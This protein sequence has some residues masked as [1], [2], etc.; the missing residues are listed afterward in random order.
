[1]KPLISSFRFWA[2]RVSGRFWKAELRAGIPRI[3][4]FGAAL[5]TIL[6]SSLPQEAQAQLLEQYLPA[7]VTGYGSV[8]GVPVLARQR[9]EFDPAG[10]RYGT[11]V[12]HPEASTGV[13]YNS[14][15]TGTSG[16]AGGVSINTTA[17]VIASS[18]WSLGSLTAFANVENTE[19]PNLSNQSTT[20]WS[21]GGAGAYQVDRDTL[22]VAAS[23]LSSYQQQTSLAALTLTTQ[24]VPF[25]V[26]D[27]RLG[28]TFRFGRVTLTPNVEMSIWR[29]GNGEFQG[30]T[31]DQTYR[32]Y[33]QL[34][35]GVTGTYELTQ[36]I[37]A[38]GVVRGFNSHYVTPQ[39]GQ[40]SRDSTSLQILGGL[41]YSTNA[42]WQYQALVGFEQ[43]NY[44]A[45]Q[46]PS[47]TAPLIEGTV[48]WSPTGLTTVTGLIRRE[49]EDA[50]NVPQVSYV[51]TLGKLSVDHEYLRYIRLNGYV[52]AQNAEYQQNGGSQTI[53][54]V[55][56]GA[57][58]LINRTLRASLTYDFSNSQSSN[59]GTNVG[60][61]GTVGTIGTGNY[62]VQTVLLSL[63]FGL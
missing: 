11:V 38:V 7:N 46:Y 24:P 31:V 4:V 30:I 28:Y 35:G 27:F 6:V 39:A 17:A 49:I 52:Q 43:R 58:W 47:H 50:A 26:D 20:D 48:I 13:G 10:I 44:A 53:A 18:D 19:Y 12:I 63:R 8:S 23:H 15:V 62:N 57:T 22:L 60:T 16:G 45:S 3:G 54:S 36:E 9:P 14:N 40:P 37:K 2:E 1:V 41:N 34:Q 59:T 32:N 33:N 29:F 42:V 61:V 56:G 21:V 5:A 55:G 51:Y 25:T